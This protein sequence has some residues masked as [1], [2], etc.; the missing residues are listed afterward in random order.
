MKA[1]PKTNL[2]NGFIK[3]SKLSID[4]PILIERSQIDLSTYVSIINTLI[5]SRSRIG[6]SYR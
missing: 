2:A 3:P 4:I 5:I 1:Y 6:I